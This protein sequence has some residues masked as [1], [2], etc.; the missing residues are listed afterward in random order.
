M[1]P[2]VTPLISSLFFGSGRCVAGACSCLF[3]DGVLFVMLNFTFDGAA[4]G[5][6]SGAASGLRGAASGLGGAAD[7][8]R[9]AAGRLRG[10]A[11]SGATGAKLGEQ[12]A[13]TMLVSVTA[14]S[15]HSTTAVRHMA[16]TAARGLQ[17]GEQ[18][19][20]A[21]ATTVTGDRGRFG[22]QHRAANEQ[23]KRHHN[24]N[25]ISTHQNSP[26]RVGNQVANPCAINNTPL[27]GPDTYREQEHLV[28]D[29]NSSFREAL[30]G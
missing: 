13:T 15:R 19:A 16:T 25:H 1:R 5:G 28:S 23:R 6:R 20:T 7:R 3:F 24:T 27:P 30:E 18:S 12:T 4:T 11:S 26:I 14:T 29:A 9:S 22:R 2:E 17:L 10:T 21:A 8:F